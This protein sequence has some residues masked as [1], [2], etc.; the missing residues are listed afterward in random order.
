[1]PLHQQVR[2]DEEA[3]RNL[4]RIQLAGNYFLDDRG[5]LSLAEDHSINLPTGNV[6][7]SPP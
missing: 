7:Q 1:M 3:R 4:L 2:L 6:E 5:L